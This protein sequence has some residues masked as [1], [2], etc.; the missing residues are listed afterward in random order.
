MLAVRLNQVKLA[1][2]RRRRRCLCR[3]RRRRRRVT[4]LVW[5]ACDVLFVCQPESA[6]WP[7]M[8][9]GMGDGWKAKDRDGYGKRQAR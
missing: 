9:N 1:L 3:R 4:V 2:L 8:G 5:N 7:E 6:R